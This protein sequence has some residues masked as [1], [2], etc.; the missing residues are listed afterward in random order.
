[1]G[2][3]TGVG[4]GFWGVNFFGAAEWCFC[5]GFWE[6]LRAERGFLMV[7]LWWLRGELWC[8]DGRILGGRNFPLFRDLF[9][10]GCG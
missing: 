2:H 4:G 8:V 7:K 5:W 3:G 6:K 9:L 10:G 1:L